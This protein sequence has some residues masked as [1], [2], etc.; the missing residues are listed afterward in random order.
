MNVVIRGLMATG[1]LVYATVH[2]LQGVRPPADAPLW[3]RLAFLATAA[4]AVVLAVGLLARRP[5]TTDQWKDAAAA[6]AGASLVALVLSWTTGF[7]GVSEADLRLSTLGVVVAEMVVLATWA[8]T[9]V[10]GHEFDE[11]EEEVPD[12]G[13][14]RG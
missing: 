4:V 7:L 3:L 12:L 10:V 14:R 2:L 13:R 5:G 9:R 11:V 1:L 6:L 8:I